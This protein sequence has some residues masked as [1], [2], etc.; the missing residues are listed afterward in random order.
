MH[1]LRSAGST[2]RSPTKKPRESTTK[3][4]C[5]G[6]GNGY[7]QQ[8]CIYALG[9][10]RYQ[11][12]VIIIDIFHPPS[13]AQMSKRNEASDEGCVI[14]MWDPPLGVFVWA[15]CKVFPPVSARVVLFVSV[16]FFLLVSLSK[17]IYPSRPLPEDGYLHRLFFLC[18]NTC[19]LC[20]FC[21]SLQLF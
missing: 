4:F 18:E 13:G 16:S 20:F 19:L 5:S 11:W 2:G 1:V 21:S 3:T 9:N 15:W 10:G 17:H 6:G 14:Q 8:C 7:S 12:E